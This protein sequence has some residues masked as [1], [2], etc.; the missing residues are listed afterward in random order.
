MRTRFNR[1]ESG[2]KE[3]R[4]QIPRPEK[5]LR[6]WYRCT[7]LHSFGRTGSAPP[8]M[9]ELMGSR[10]QPP[11]LGP[12]ISCDQKLWWSHRIL[13]FGLVGFI[14][15]V[16]SFSRMDNNKRLS[17]E[18]ATVRVMIE[19]YCSVHHSKADG[20]CAACET[21]YQYASRMIARCPFHEAKPVCAKCLIHCYSPEMRKEMRKAM[22]FSGPLLLLIHPGLALLHALDRVRNPSR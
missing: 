5:S 7:G 14:G 3:T 20:M 2:R 9:H 1:M 6:R 11:F 16:L 22:T 10:F 18:R 19:M 15:K 12:M 21:L 13:F 4:G 17:R 8:G